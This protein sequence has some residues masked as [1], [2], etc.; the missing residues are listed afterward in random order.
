[1]RRPAILVLTCPHRHGLRVIQ[2][3]PALPVEPQFAI[4]RPGNVRELKHG[5]NNVAFGDRSV[6]L[7]SIANCGD[8]VSEV[9][10]CGDIAV[11]MV[12]ERNR[13]VILET[14]VLFPLRS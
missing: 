3:L 2:N 13:A 14:P 6:Q 10:N 5:N 11:E 8:Q 4:Q 1:M 7:L 9:G 12:K